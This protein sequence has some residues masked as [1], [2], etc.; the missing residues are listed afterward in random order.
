MLTAGLISLTLK[1]SVALICAWALTSAMARYSAASRHLVWTVGLIAMFVLPAAHLV[2]PR[3]ELAF[4]PAPPPAQTQQSAIGRLAEQ[5]SDVPE[6]ERSFSTPAVWESS[7]PP[8]VRTAISETDVN[9]ASIVIA[10]WLCGIA[11]GLL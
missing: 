8:G 4:L 10:A 11:L 7:A 1:V 9:R 3:W 2:G 6:N 5:A